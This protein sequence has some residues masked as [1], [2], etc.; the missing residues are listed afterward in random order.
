MLRFFATCTYIGGFFGAIA[1]LVGMADNSAPRAAASAAMAIGLVVIPYCITKIFWISRQVDQFA[2]LQKSLFR[3]NTVLEG[4][5]LPPKTN[6][7]NN[8]PPAA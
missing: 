7:G 3:I 4:M 5:Q 6:P 8:E 1:L 2:E